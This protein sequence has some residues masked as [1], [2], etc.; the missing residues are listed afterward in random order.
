LLARD[1][2]EYKLA[3]QHLIYPMLDDRTCVTTTPNPIA[4]EFIWTPHNNAYGWAALLGQAPGGPE[5]SPYAAAARANDF[6][7]LPPAFIAVPTL[8]LF[9]DEDIAYAQR[10]MRAGVPVELH[11]YPG[12]FHGF[13]IFGGGAPIAVQAR[14]DSQSALKSAL[15]G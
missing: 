5:I 1:R 14:S 10:L 15:G 12:G 2:G 3:F 8:D 11:V 9:V 4:G 7:G 6:A 13:D